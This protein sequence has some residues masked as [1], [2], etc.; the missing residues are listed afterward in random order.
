MDAGSKGSHKSQDIYRTALCL[1]MLGC[2]GIELHCLYILVFWYITI[3]CKCYATLAYGKGI[4]CS[5]LVYAYA[6]FV[7]AR[8][9]W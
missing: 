9:L 6:M 1:F 5:T 8:L 2:F 4:C 7:Y 3:L